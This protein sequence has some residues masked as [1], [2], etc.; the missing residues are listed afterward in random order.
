MSNSGTGKRWELIMDMTSENTTNHERPRSGSFVARE[1]VNPE[2]STRRSAHA[3][4]ESHLALRL[5]NDVEGDIAQN[6]SHDVVLM[7]C[8]GTF[9]GHDG[10]R[11]SARELA[12]YLPEA[13]F[14]YVLRMVER[15]VAFL[16]WTGQS[17]KGTVR[18]GVDTFVVREGKIVAQT[19][20]YTVT[21]SQG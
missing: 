2:D 11:A 10:V 15:D 7:T 6:Y 5:A 8:T 12:G 9:H 4:F 18:D 16:V 14:T 21:P 3:V 19:I 13:K 20:H 1:R 17:E